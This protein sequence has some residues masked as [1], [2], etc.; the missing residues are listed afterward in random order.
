[1]PAIKH[2][3]DEIAD[4]LLKV[5]GCDDGIERAK[6][7]GIFGM[8]FDEAIPILRQLGFTE[9]A[10]W[11]KA[12]K[13]TPQ[14]VYYNG[15]EI[16]MNTSFQVFNPTTG[17]HMEYESEEEALKAIEEIAQGIIKAYNVAICREISNENGDTA[18]EPLPL[19]FNVAVKTSE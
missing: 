5:S 6:D 16:N 15:R 8:E 4:L 17:R 9:D 13:R 11:L 7:M 10:A 3:E 2:T 18:W 1:M 14:Y 12:I 19:T